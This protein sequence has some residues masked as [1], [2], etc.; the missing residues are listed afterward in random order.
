MNIQECELCGEPVADYDGLVLHVRTQEPKCGF[1][2]PPAFPESAFDT[3][4]GE[5]G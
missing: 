4:L 1:T 2:E 3:P 5:A